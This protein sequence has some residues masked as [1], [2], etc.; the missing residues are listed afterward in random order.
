MCNVKYLVVILIFPFILALSACGGGDGEAPP[1]PPP[2]AS[3]QVIAVSPTQSSDTA[4]VTSL[5]TAQFDREMEPTT[6]TA[7]SFYVCCDVNSNNIAG[8]LTFQGSVEIATFTPSED[9]DP[10]KK[11]TA[12]ITTDVTDSAGNPL[13]R[14]YVWDFTVAPK[15]VLVSTNSS[16]IVVSSGVVITHDV[17]P[18]QVFSHPSAINVTGE[19]V[20]FTSKE[21]LDPR[22][23][24]SGI[25]VFRKNTIT[26]HTEL[27]SISQDNQH[28]ANK[29]CD[30]PRISDTGRYIVFS[31]MANNL[32][33]TITE[34]RGG[35]HIFLKDM[36]VAYK[37]ITLLD[38]D[39]LNSSRSGNGTSA[40]P[41]IS[42]GTFV[43]FEST[44]PD[45]IQ[46]SGVYTDTNGTISD[47]FRYNTGNGKVEVV[48]FNTTSNEQPASAGSF[49]PRISVDGQ[50]I[51]FQSAAND[52]VTGHSGS[53]VDIFLYEHSPS[54]P[55]TVL[56][57]VDLNGEQATGGDSSNAEISSDGQYVVYQ[58]N[59][60]NLN[61]NAV[62]G[63]FLSDLTDLTTITSDRMSVA[64]DGTEANYISTNP[65]ISG[66]AGY[67]AFQSKATNLIL[68]DV[69]GALS[70]VFVRPRDG[71]HRIKRLSVDNQDIQG[72][73]INK[74]VAISTDGRY[75]SFTTPNKFTDDMT[76][77]NGNE[78]IYRAYNAALP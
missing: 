62:T 13:A 25:Q 77:N 15:Q 7:S 10:G 37:T 5:V 54:S 47:I 42:G 75:V 44:A 34:Y 57:N 30:A 73:S 72:N 64:A 16:G 21:A 68:P 8:G 63:I 49:R 29:D 66:D 4:L 3:P 43:A 69:N 60:T 46:D 76:D 17:D 2:P 24:T 35:S 61:T 27:V 6:I 36:N 71:A 38:R 67:I 53:Y 50:R 55:S 32:D 1:P 78:D 40:N 33:P 48:S 58:S 70:D 39:A 28:Y 9:L 31:S 26:G 65:S 14:N 19:Y 20:V 12:T 11:Y 51:V 56:V 18:E 23:N 74:N 52:L 41:D 45:L 59:A 22:Y